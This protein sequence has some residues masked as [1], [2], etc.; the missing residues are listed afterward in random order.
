[1]NKLIAQ[2][3]AIPDCKVIPVHDPYLPSLENLPDDLADFYKECGGA[4]LFMHRDFGF[5]IV[6]PNELIPANRVIFGDDYYM[7]HREELDMD[8]TGDWYVIAV[9]CGREEMICINLGGERKGFCYDGF[10]DVYGTSACAIVALSFTELVGRLVDVK[11]LALYWKES[12][13]PA[14]GFAR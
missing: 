11:G 8:I 12:G 2:L 5:R 3:A 13:A 14:Y 10:W 4:E 1:M 9:G 6:G 7:A